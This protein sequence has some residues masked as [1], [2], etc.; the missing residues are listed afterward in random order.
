MVLSVFAFLIPLFIFVQ[1]S[2]AKVYKPV[3]SPGAM[4]IPT[5]APKEINSFEL[6]WPIAAG[7]TL[8]EP[9]YSLKILKEQI[10]GAL[11]FGAAQKSDY[12]VFLSTKRIVEAEELLKENKND[13]ALKTWETS[14]GLLEKAK[15]SWLKA[16]E[17]STEG[18]P[19]KENI[20][21]QLTNLHTF[22]TYLSTKYGGDIKSKID[23]N[24]QKIQEFLSS[25]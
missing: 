9:L 18:G 12:L 3:T 20:R 22:L 16:K 11:K 17:A 5:A 21:K 7:K 6:F 14:L 13:L 24:N 10:R 23:Q 1:V 2:W 19:E 25:L 4:P 15:V 8:G